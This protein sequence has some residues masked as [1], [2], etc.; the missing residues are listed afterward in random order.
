MRGY[1]APLTKTP[2]DQKWGERDAAFSLRYE[3]TVSS[4]E[5]KPAAPEHARSLS[6]KISRKEMLPERLAAALFVF[7]RPKPVKSSPHPEFFD[8]MDFSPYI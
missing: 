4:Q 1:H 3:Q 2:R 5:S 7:S 6:S 8:P